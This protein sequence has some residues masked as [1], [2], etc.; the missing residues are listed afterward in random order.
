MDS[1]S[2]RLHLKAQASQIQKIQTNK[3][4]KFSQHNE[5]TL[6]VH[7][8][9][10]SLHGQDSQAPEWHLELDRKA[11]VRRSSEEGHSFN[12]MFIHSTNIYFGELV[13]DRYKEPNSPTTTASP[14]VPL[15]WMRVNVIGLM[16]HKLRLGEVGQEEGKSVQAGGR[17]R[18]C[19]CSQEE[20]GMQ[21][22][23]LLHIFLIQY[24]HAS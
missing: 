11:Q 3:I 24:L 4:S 5:S 2:L 9:S 20:S 16:R 13:K 7:P 8:G 22:G 15:S 14:E 18:T 21:Q 12:H 23:W 10:N 19:S 1:H 6:S 17:F